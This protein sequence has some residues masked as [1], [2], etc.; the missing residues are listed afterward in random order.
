VNAVWQLAAV[1]SCASAHRRNTQSGEDC[2]SDE[3]RHREALADG[4]ITTL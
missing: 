3:Q 2:G 1:S 4:I